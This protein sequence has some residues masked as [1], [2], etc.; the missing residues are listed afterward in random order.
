MRI[1]SFLRSPWGSI[2]TPWSDF[3]ALYLF[4]DFL[5]IFRG[6]GTRKTMVLHWRGCY[7]A[8]SLTFD[9]CHFWA[10][11]W[12]PFLVIWD[13]K[14][15]QM[16]SGLILEA[17]HGHLGATFVACRFPVFFGW[18]P[19][20]P[21]ISRPEKSGGNYVVFGPYSQI[22]EDSRLATDSKLV[23]RDKKTSN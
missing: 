5:F 11:F 18:F 20:P 17:L 23:T 8:F 12:S 21:Q 19:E 1:C 22:T 2:L 10:P 14:W 16:P 4:I 7:F 6:P 13:L 9:F 3:V 15:S